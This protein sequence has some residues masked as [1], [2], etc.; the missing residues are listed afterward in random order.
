MDCG[1]EIVA[2]KRT[3]HHESRVQNSFSRRL[4]SSLAFGLSL[5]GPLLSPAV[6]KVDGYALANYLIVLSLSPVSVNINF[7][8][9]YACNILI[10]PV[11]T[12]PRIVNCK[13]ESLMSH[14]LQL[15]MHTTRA[16]Y[17]D[18]YRL[19]ELSEDVCAR[20]V[21]LFNCLNYKVI[22]YIVLYMTL[23]KIRIHHQ[24]TL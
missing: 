6:A 24:A 3:L 11:L 4:K 10:V 8:R 1:N 21:P 15:H 19:F 9:I 7:C 22:T 17:Q 23:C 2:I 13:E 5:L 20:S 16:V 12:R 18:N 14:G